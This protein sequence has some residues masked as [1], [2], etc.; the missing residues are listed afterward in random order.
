MSTIS[1]HFRQL[2]FISLGLVLSA[3]P[4]MA[5][6]K[7]E[8]PETSFD[9][10]VRVQKS[11]ADLVYLLPGADLSP[12]TEILL[13]EPFVAFHKD[14]QDY[15][16]S[17]AGPFDRISDKDMEKM[18]KGIKELFTESFTET[19]EKKG[20]PVVQEV[21]KTVLIVRPAVINVQVAVPDPDRMKGM[22]RGGV[23]TENAGA[24]TFFVELYDSVSQQI[25]A[26]AI[27]YESDI[28][29]GWRIPRDYSSNRR[30]ADNTFSYW[31]KML[32]NGLDRAKEAASTDDVEK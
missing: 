17:N 21:G 14:W 13:L 15:H 8:P 16:N 25:L 27:D 11:K 6:K 28:D 5:A 18:I 1:Q 30:A 31:A 7:A 19:L 22:G 4:A 20:F 23:Y 10:L 26:R 29:E 32:A 3:S 12:Y 9:G 24:M 2:L